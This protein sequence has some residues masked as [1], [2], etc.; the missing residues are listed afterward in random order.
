MSGIEKSCSEGLIR[1][2]VYLH[3]WYLDELNAAVTLRNE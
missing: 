2:Q 3:R 1:L